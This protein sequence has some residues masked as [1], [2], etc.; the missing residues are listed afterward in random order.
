MISQRNNIETPTI[1]WSHFAANRHKKGTG[2]SYSLFSNYQVACMTATNFPNAKRG[3][4]ETAW[5]RKLVVPLPRH[6][7]SDFICST[8]LLT[9]DMVVEAEVTKRQ[10]GE[11]LFV[12]SFTRDGVSERA[13]FVNVVIYSSEA[14]LEND[15][16]RTTDCDWEIVAL[17]CSP[18]ENEPMHPLALARNFLNKPGGTKSTYTAEELAK[19]IYYWS[20]RINVK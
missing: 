3:Q 20:Q 16:E 2:F 19:S 11:D 5:N 12:S 15:G 13:E 8:C 10:E 4:G 14:L 9:E 6:D 1:G 17:L 18:V 7:L